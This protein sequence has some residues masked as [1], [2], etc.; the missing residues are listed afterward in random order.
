MSPKVL[1]TIAMERGH[2]DQ[3]IV[4]FERAAAINEGYLPVSNRRVAAVIQR[5]TAPLQAELGRGDLALDLIRQA[6]LEL[7]GDIKLTVITGVLA[8]LV[9]ALRNERDLALARIAAEEGRKKV[10]EDRTTQRSFFYYLSRAALLID[11]PEQAETWLRAYLELKL[12]PLYR[13]YS[14]Y[15]LAECRRRLGNAVGGR[16]FD[17]R[18]ASTQFGT[19]CGSLARER[20]AAVGATV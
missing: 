2:L 17:N 15:H 6:E 5:S 10:P 13:P 19:R 18:A 12:D 4:A 8:A 1:G 11:E 14:Y 7:A 16:E 20:L 9:H 3:A